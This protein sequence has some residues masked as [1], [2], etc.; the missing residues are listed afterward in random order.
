MYEIEA[1]AGDGCGGDDDIEVVDGGFEVAQGDFAGLGYDVGLHEFSVGQEAY[2]CAACR[3]GNGS[4][5]TRCGVGCL[6]HE[7]SP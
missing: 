5:R 4:N 6:R 7:N 2:A 1:H 3:G